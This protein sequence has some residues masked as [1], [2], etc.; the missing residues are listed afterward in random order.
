M[1]TPIVQPIL[2]INNEGQELTPVDEI[3]ISSVT[4]NNTFDIYQDIIEAYL[5]DNQD[6]FIS[7]L[8]TNYNVTQGLVSGSTITSLNLDPGR[9]VTA[10]NYQQG[11]YKVDYN[12]LR[13]LVQGNLPFTITE[14]SSDRTELRVQNTTL[15]Q[16]QTRV[17]EN[18]IR[19]T[20][21]STETFQGYYL[22]L[23]SDNILLATNVA[24]DN[25]TILVKLYAPLPDTYAVSTT[26]TFVKKVS[27]PV[28]FSVE[29]PQEEIII[30]TGKQLN[31][32]NLNIQLQRQTNNSTTYTNYQS[33]V[34]ASNPSLSNQLFS[35]L[36][37]RRAELNTDY[38]DYSNFVF[39]SSAE[40]RLANFY[41]K[42]SLIE[43]YNTQI[44]ILNAITTTTEVS[45]STAVYQK[46]IEDIITNFDGYD[47]YLYYESGSTAWPKTNTV[48]PYTLYSTGSAEVLQW[49]ATQSLSASLYDN[50]NSNYIYNVYP[51]YL[52][53]D[54]DNSQ[55]QLF[56]DMVAQMFDQIW[57]YTK[58]LENRQDNDN[59]LGGGISVD[60]VG[61]A[62]R[63]YG[64]TLY[65]SNFTNSDLYT[66][67][68]G[69]TNTGGTL[70]PTGSELITTYITA[71]AQT[72]AFNDAQKLIYK[73][74]YHN[75]P[76]L[77]KKKGTISGLRVLLN[78]F[79]IPDTILRISEYGGKDKN[80]NT[81]DYWADEFTYALATQGTTYLTSSFVANTTWNAISNRPQ[82]VA[83]R[84]KTPGIPTASYYSQSLWST[85]TGAGLVLKYTGSAY[86]SGSY[87]GS[88]VNPYYEYGTLIYYPTSSNLNLS[89]SI[90]LPFFDG[91]WWSVLVNNNDSGSFTI[92]AGNNIYEGVDGNTVGF[93]ASSSVSASN[94][95]NSATI[96]YLGT[97]SFSAKIFSG[98]F[99]ELRYYVNPVSKSVFDDYVMNP[100][101]IEG[102]QFNASGKELIFRA[103]L[104]NELYTG[105]TSIHPKVTG[106]WATTSS[107]S[108]TSNF[109]F[110]NSPTYLPDYGYAYY[111]Q[112]PAGIQNAVA[113]KIKVVQIQ[114]PKSGSDNLPD[115]KTLS[116]FR[117]IQQDYEVSGSITR[118]VN[119]VE[120]GLSPQNEINDDINTSIGYFNIG[121][122]IGDPRDISSDLTYYPGLETL[123]EEYFSKY[124]DKYNWTDYIR[125]IKYFDNSVFRMVKDFI[126]ARAAA[127]TGIIIKQHLLERNRQRPAQASYTQPEYTASIASAARNY[128]TGSIEV[129]TGGPG[130]V[131]DNWVDSSQPWSSSINTQAGIVETLNSSKYEFYNGEYSG[132][133]VRSVK[134]PNGNNP[135][136]DS[137]YRVGI[138]DLQNLTATRTT[139]FTAACVELVSGSYKT[140]TSSIPFPFN[141]SNLILPYYN[142]STYK[143]TPLYPVQV[144]IQVSIS[145]SY[146]QANAADAE[147]FNVDLYLVET[148]EGVKNI[149]GLQSFNTGSDAGPFPAANP[150]NFSQTFSNV[151]IRSGSTYSIE[152]IGGCNA[153]ADDVG[154]FE[155]AV[156]G[157]S[158][159]VTVDNL[160][161]QSTYY[162]DPT[163]YTQQNF[164]GN[165]NRYA[166][167]NVLLN[168]VYSNRVSAEY[169]QVDYSTDAY[170]PVNYQAIISQSAIYAQVQDSNYV[171]ES[172][173]THA[174]YMGSKN[175]GQ[176]NLTQS[177]SSQSVAPGYPI[178]TFANYFVYFDWIGGSDPQYPG[179]GNIH[180]LTLIGIDG[181]GIPLT[182]G[183]TNLQLIENLYVNGNTATIWPTQTGSVLPIATVEIVTGGAL[184]ESI[185][186]VTGSST[187]PSDF[188]APL[189]NGITDQQLTA[190][191]Y[192]VF[193]SG[194][195][196]VL[197]DSGSLAQS[198]LIEHGWISIFTNRSSS[199]GFVDYFTFENNGSTTSKI[200]F[201][202][203]QN[204][205]YTGSYP[206]IINYSDTRLPL[207]YGDIIRFGTTGTYSSTN[208]AS[209]DG[210]FA[211][212][213][214]FEIVRIDTG[215]SSRV[216]SSIEITPLLSQYTYV[217]NVAI[218]N[219]LPASIQDLEQNFRIMRRVPNEVF[220][221]ITR[222]PT[223]RGS[224]FLVPENFN[225][226][227][228]IYELARKA[229]VI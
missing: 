220:I 161:A 9:D 225:P 137:A 147:A 95:W 201:V 131:V 179:G 175:T 224:G 171:P 169:E 57:L 141:Q 198:S 88:V 122:Y 93:S 139:T 7:R 146:L 120:I 123:S 71:S 89:A 26:F 82:A 2:P 145:A 155:F 196:T 97:S 39:F 195:K 55:F 142:T 85:N 144:D 174:R 15:N 126:P 90:Y 106:S 199:F 8:T 229:G 213:G 34:S 32:P 204:G 5:Y 86:T 194:S 40:Q 184:Y 111:D 207:Q 110:N 173:W 66:S 140:T 75:L 125:L 186:V 43:N 62:L 109:Y 118:N 176:Y 180:G 152:Y 165:I 153:S 124:I 12:F 189:I 48:K 211:G 11:S 74:L 19:Q 56:N 47:Y 177:Y 219:P 87:S 49:Y 212:G 116:T 143:Y 81:W 228:N 130:G 27:E 192:T 54:P 53:E 36:T 79:G 102:N 61:D 214:L 133:T 29:F 205:T 117:S 193:T 150:F 96:S 25:N 70:P 45:A 135:L 20:L 188:S 216:R 13:P 170:K 112:V 78:C 164:P 113:K 162:T 21:E 77:L 138:P 168:N 226:N 151:Y 46:K 127:A 200:A 181:V 132:S 134:Y 223:Y 73:R 178:D 159:T 44:G 101:S 163:V 52:T 129:F 209:L 222:I 67:Y 208:T 65:E 94:S 14:I 41:Y 23:G 1:A 115:N 185:L 92:Y 217:N 172:A 22:D 76:Y 203:K 4:I 83:F 10:N 148:S 18:T 84:F 58:A 37:E 16:D 227:Y 149:L 128:E 38:S 187:G 33:L 98:S 100:S 72:T 158:W 215:S 59:T 3:S 206:Q 182:T 30:Q 80:P 24:Y 197:T 35:I 51:T 114:L 108:G 68:L 136:L 154:S 60:L 167:Y 28:A 190:S 191:I 64:V 104:G 183:N 63:S 69:L 31:G 121:E 157:T 107:F 221:V 17:V 99:Q 103:S 50:Q 218:K 119:Y 166:D 210:T 42:A 105:S 6:N 156:T 160:F 202:N 91:G